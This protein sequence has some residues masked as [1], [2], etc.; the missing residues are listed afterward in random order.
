MEGIA[1]TMGSDA[2]DQHPRGGLPCS[3]SVIPM[4]SATQLTGTPTA[5][6]AVTL[7][8]DTD[9]ALA[10]W[11]GNEVLRTYAGNGAQ[12]ALTDLRIF[13]SRCPTIVVSSGLGVGDRYRFAVAPGPPTGDDSIHVRDSMTSDT[14]TVEG[15]SVLV[16]IGTTLVVV[17]EQ[18]NKPGGDKYLTQ[19]AEAA[20]RRY[21]ATGP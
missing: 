5:M 17:Q 16:R 12:Q 3:D 7:S 21:Q 1:T 20:L 6:A 2:G 18:A 15:D 11:V 10:G 19:L 14:D 9:P 8:N 13:I 4:L